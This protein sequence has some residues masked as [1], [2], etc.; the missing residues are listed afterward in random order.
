MFYNISHY[1]NFIMRLYKGISV[2]ISNNKMA[3]EDNRP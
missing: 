2:N 3:Y 1:L